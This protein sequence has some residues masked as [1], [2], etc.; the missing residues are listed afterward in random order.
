MYTCVVINMCESVPMAD[1]NVCVGWS[2]HGCIP[3]HPRWP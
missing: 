2:V 1:E 3:E